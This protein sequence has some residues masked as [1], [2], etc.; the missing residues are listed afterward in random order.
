LADTRSVKAIFGVPDVSMNRVK[1]G[2]RQAITTD[3]LP[4]EIDG[5]VTAVSPA[6]DPKSHVYS[7][8]VTVPNPQNQL[9]T[10]MIASL[11]LAGRPLAHARLAI[12]LAAVIRDPQQANSFAVLVPEGTGDTEK[13]VSRKVE[14]G[15]A[16]GNMIEVLHGVKLGERVVTTG[17]TLVQS[18]DQVRIIP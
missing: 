11:T 18:G 12:P 2:S 16:Y 13:V 14:L 15:D 10:G 8:E 7:V 17:A 3:V 1:L 5:R 9:K 6:A 4:G